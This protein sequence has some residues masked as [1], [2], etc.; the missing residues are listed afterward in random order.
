MYFIAREFNNY[1]SHRFTSYLFL[2]N[3][4]SVYVGRISMHMYA[5][6]CG[7]WKSTV[8]SFSG[9]TL[10]FN[11]FKC[12]VLCNLCTH[13]PIDLFHLPSRKPEPIKYNFLLSFPTAPDNHHSI[14]CVSETDW[15]SYLM[16]VNIYIYLSLWSVSKA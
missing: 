4:L 13:P 1:W 12:T 14:F 10:D 3:L 11:K 8:I 2:I 5:L 15:S 9:G 7:M 6:L 16:W